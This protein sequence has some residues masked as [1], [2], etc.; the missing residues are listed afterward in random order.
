MSF[1]HVHFNFFRH[2]SNFFY[3]YPLHMNLLLLV[4]GASVSLLS[5]S[6]VITGT[7]WTVQCNNLEES[8]KISTYTVLMCPLC[9]L[10]AEPSNDDLPDA[11]CAKKSVSGRM[12][13]DLLQLVFFSLF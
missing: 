2:T 8:I 13:N 7:M 3:C 4:C 12:S 11:E 10:K 6:E 1:I 9:C 5:M